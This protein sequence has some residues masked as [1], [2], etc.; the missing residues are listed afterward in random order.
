MQRKIH[1]QKKKKSRIAKVIGLGA[2]FPVIMGHPAIPLQINNDCLLLLEHM[3][4][5]CRS[6]R[7]DRPWIPCHSPTSTFGNSRLKSPGGNS[8]LEENKG[9]AVHSSLL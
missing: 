1:A 4:I 9:M 8:E 5:S 2:S 6:S 3:A 7:V